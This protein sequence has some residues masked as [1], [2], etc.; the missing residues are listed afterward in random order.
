M[1][2]NNMILLS[3]FELNDNNRGSAALGYGAI[4]FLIEKGLYSAGDEFC[5]MSR[6]DK[7]FWKKRNFVSST[8]VKVSNR[9]V[10]VKLIRYFDLEYKAYLKFGIC[11][12]LSPLGRLVKKLKFVAA[13]NGGDGFSDIYSE[14]IFLNRLTESWMAMK[15]K[16]DLYLLPQTMGPF[17]NSKLRKIADEILLY[18]KKIYVRDDKFVPELNKMGLSFEREKDLSAYMMPEPWA[19]DVKPNAVGINVSGLAYFNKF[20]TLSGH[21]EAYPLLVESLIKYFQ[22]QGRPIYLIPHSYNYV[23]PEYA[24]DDMI[25]CKEVYRQLSDKSRIY[26]VDRDLTAPQIKYVISKMSF[27]CGTRMHA[28]FA[29]IYTNVPVFGL[30]YSYKFAG[31]FESNGLSAE[32][33]YMIDNMS[34]KEIPTVISIIEDFYKKN[35]TLKEDGTND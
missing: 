7:K 25:A 35:V 4:A 8:Q 21:F 10:N 30:A 14:P 6:M 16:K 13:T 32:Q 31:A 34:I 5:V 29:A 17:V 11:F 2:M 33:T 15:E 26:V 20:M 12:P 27:F 22:K 28:N 23:K 18:A 24:N 1:I 3:G 9:F 19:Y